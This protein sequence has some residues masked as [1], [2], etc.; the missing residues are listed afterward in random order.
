MADG[1][2]VRLEE[3]MDYNT[4]Y[5]ECSYT[6]RSISR[7]GITYT[8]YGGYNSWSGANYWFADNWDNNGGTAVRKRLAIVHNDAEQKIIEQLLN[9]TSTVDKA[10]IGASKNGNSW[11]TARF[12]RC[13]GWIAG[14][15]H[16]RL[17]GLR[18]PEV[19]HPAGLCVLH[20]RGRVREHAGC[21]HLRQ[22]RQLRMAVGRGAG[23]PAR[24]AVHRVKSTSESSGADFPQRAVCACFRGKNSGFAQKICPIPLDKTL[25]LCYN[26]HV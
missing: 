16:T 15:R 3:N 2:W 23:H 24:H 19:H 22:R 13:A 26:N 12:S 14:H 10:W 18:E 6:G 1:G 8:L 5:G 21:R 25:S 20:R 4:V 9:A 17:R 7:N 11:A